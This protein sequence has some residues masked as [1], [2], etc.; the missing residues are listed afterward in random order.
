M[1]VGQS[2]MDRLINNAPLRRE[3]PEQGVSGNLS[4]ALSEHI[5][6]EAAPVVDV[7]TNNTPSL[8][9]STR[10]NKGRTTKYKDYET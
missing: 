6:D 7:N 4:P 9:R 10:S 8:R 3:L 1:P 5:E 2:G